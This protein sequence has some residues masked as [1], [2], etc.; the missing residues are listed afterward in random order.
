MCV[1]VEVSDHL[2]LLL[3][4]VRSFF[5]FTLSETTKSDRSC[6]ING[7]KKAKIFVF[8]KR[9][10]MTEAFETIDVILTKEQADHINV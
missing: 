5:S 6:L 9:N 2:L 3:R 7:F 10:I 8:H 4:S 1:T